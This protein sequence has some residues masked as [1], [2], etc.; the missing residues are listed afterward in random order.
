MIIS[1]FY[2][3]KIESYSYLDYLNTNKF[4]S[5]YSIDGSGELLIRVK[6]VDFNKQPVRNRNVSLSVN[7]G[8]FEKDDV[9]HSKVYTLSEDKK[10]ISGNTNDD[11]SICVHY[12]NA[13]ERGICTF[14]SNSSVIQI[15]NLN[16]YPIGSI[17]MSIYSTNPA[18][19][20]GGEWEQIG[21]GRTLIGQGTGV[22]DNNVS[23]TFVNEESK[24]EYN[25]TLTINEMPSHNHTQNK[26][27]HKEQNKYSSNTGK[28]KAYVYSSNRNAVDHYTDYQQ[29]AINP[30]GGGKAHNN[31][32]PYFVVYMW[33]RKK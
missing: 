10:T 8:Y 9:V 7:L 1:D 28:E 23:R 26:H 14:S 19:L 2:Q 18:T 4:N 15:D 20:F 25:H 11:G 29:P 27:R 12:K 22:D 21:Q 33:K 3:T 17:Y 24:G 13:S 5:C 31:L 6:L 16:P 30:T 32:P